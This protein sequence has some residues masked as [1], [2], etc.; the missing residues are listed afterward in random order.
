MDR[1]PLSATDSYRYEQRF[2]TQHRGTD[3]LAPAGSIVYAVEDGTAWATVDPKGGNVVYLEGDRSG[4]RYYYAH[5][6]RWAAKLGIAN[7]PKV[8]VMAG[9][10]LGA[11]GTTGN[12]AGG[13]PHLHFQMRDGSLVMDPFDALQ[14]VD[15]HRE[16]GS[17]P[18]M[19]GPSVVV[20][21]LALWMLSK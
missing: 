21:L 11:V 8:R 14:A 2:T 20:L 18:S 7:D 4:Y 9:D 12:A 17:R 16:R 19:V 3:I 6:S 15:P 1:F 5:L 13:P 10:D